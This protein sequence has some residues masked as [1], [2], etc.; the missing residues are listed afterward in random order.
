MVASRNLARINHAAWSRDRHRCERYLGHWDEEGVDGAGDLPLRV[1]STWTSTAHIEERIPSGALWS[2]DYE[3]NVAG[4]GTLS[5]PTALREEAEVAFGNGS[6]WGTSTPQTGASELAG[7]W[8]S[9][10]SDIWIVGT[11]GTILHYLLTSRRERVGA[12]LLL[13]RKEAV[14]PQKSGFSR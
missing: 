8:G 11:G 6:A 9:S 10:A 13:P 2:A 3:R 7:V 14:C 1:G 4:M 12:F 5:D